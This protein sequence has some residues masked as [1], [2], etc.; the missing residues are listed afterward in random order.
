MK[1]HSGGGQKFN[2]EQMVWLR[3]IRDHTINSFHIE[4]DDLE[5][6]P[7]DSQG[8]MGKMYQLFGTNMDNLLNEL[9]EA[10]TA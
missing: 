9:N 2:E 1:Y 6:A 10:L 5:T 7:F 4:R 3:M 8:G